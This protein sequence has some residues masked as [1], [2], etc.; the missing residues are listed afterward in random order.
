MGYFPMEQ[1]RRNKCGL[2]YRLQVSHVGQYS[3]KILRH[4]DETEDFDDD[5]RQVARVVERS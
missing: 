5:L 2:P 3:E 4:L 1:L